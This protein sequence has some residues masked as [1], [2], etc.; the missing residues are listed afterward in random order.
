MFNVKHKPNFEDT[1]KTRKEEDYD[2]EED[3]LGE[4]WIRKFNGC[5]YV[6]YAVEAWGF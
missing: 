1:K 2:E 6:E 3:A 5:A 4:R